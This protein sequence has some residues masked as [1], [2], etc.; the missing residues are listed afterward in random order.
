MAD[1]V[2][3]LEQKK[4][5]AYTPHGEGRNPDGMRV[6]VVCR[7]LMPDYLL[8]LGGVDKLGDLKNGGSRCSP[9]FWSQ[10]LSALEGCTQALLMV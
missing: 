6:C 5:G 9:T 2:A 7:P 4:E 1:R 3:L 8:F 10:Y